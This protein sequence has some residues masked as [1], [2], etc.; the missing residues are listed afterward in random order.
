MATAS[1]HNEETDA[2]TFQSRLKNFRI[3]GLFGGA[4]INISFPFQTEVSSE[5]SIL[6]LSGRNGSG[7]TTI[8]RMI[9]GMLKL[10]FD[11][12]RKIPFKSAF[13]TLSTED[14]LSVEWQNE[15]TKFPLKVEFRSYS[16][17]LAKDKNDPNYDPEH[18][19]A[20]DQLRKDALPILQGINYDFLELDRSFQQRRSID[21]PSFYLDKNG[22]PVQR[23]AERATLAKKVER[24]LRDAQ[25]N[26]RRFFRSEELEFL[27]KILGRLREDVVAP[28]T[29][30]LLTRIDAIEAKF[31]L[32]N[33]YGL[34]TDED[35]MR[36]LEGLI[37]GG[38]YPSVQQLSLIETYLEMQEGAQKARDL[39]AKRLVEFE[40]IMDE[41]LV[42][43][44]VRINR[45]KG[46][47]ITT[48][49]AELTEA[50]LSS[51]EYHFLYMMVAALLCQ[52]TG[53]VIAIDEPELSLHVSWQRKLISALAKCAAGASPLF[54]FATHSL[55]IASE[56]NDKV[57]KLSA[58]D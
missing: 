45:L 55:V 39:I 9:G 44:A 17:L 48:G 7:K 14:V 38:Q 3:E 52:R 8:L 47:L 10:D 11:E 19:E 20:I 34:H 15:Q 42:G 58:V 24:F 50:Q 43:K 57:Q 28:T 6:I 5:P 21:E 1:Q 40:G 16:V 30:E 51:G 4:S 12:F 33:R 26:Y 53:S 35:Q 31:P 32:M 49:E 29:G 46:L 37:K 2:P 54:L 22:M 18:R 25:I 27:P 36:S 13:L 56:H 23:Q 41:F